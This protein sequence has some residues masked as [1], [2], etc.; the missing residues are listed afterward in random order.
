VIVWGSGIVIGFQNALAVMTA[1]GFAAAIWGVR[2]PELGLIGVSILCTLDAVMRALLMSGGLLRWN[3]LNYWLILVSLLFFRF[4]QRTN[5]WHSFWAK[6]LILFL[7]AELLISPDVDLGIQHLLGL[8]PLFGLLTYFVR[9]DTDDRVWMWIALVNGASGALGGLI[10]NVQRD[11]V[12]ALNTNAWGFF[13][14]TAIFAVGLSFPFFSSRPYVALF[15][16][17]LAVVNLCWVFLSGSRGDLLMGTAC[18][19][20]MLATMRHVPA[21]AAFVALTLVLAG[22]ILGAFP[23]LQERSLFRIEKLMDPEESAEGR[24]SG[25]SDLLVGGWYIFTQNPF[26][27]GTGAFATTW[28]GLGYVEGVSGFKYGEEMAAHAGWLKVLA[29][30]GIVGF[31]LLVAFVG[32]FAAIAWK[33]RRTPTARVGFLVTAVLTLAFTSTEFQPR[34]LWFLAAGAAAI[35]NREDLRRAM[36]GNHVP[37]RSRVGAAARP[38]PPP[39]SRAPV[40]SRPSVA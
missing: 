16:G 9:G 2:Q 8:V 35:M 5:D 18:I 10:Y 3:T 19:L 33:K 30:N 17:L 6:L 20:F 40:A 12:A 37:A 14:L 4:V 29:E 11:S 32:S 21:R 39:T 7:A 26:G 23:E 25:R 22:T 34:G 24:T 38:G 36:A 13:P 28:A 31:A 27:V 15:A 1:I